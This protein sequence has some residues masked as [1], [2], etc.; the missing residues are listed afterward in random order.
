MILGLPKGLGLPYPPPKIRVLEAQNFNFRGLEVRLCTQLQSH[1]HR[2]TKDPEILI[3]LMPQL[4][5]T[6][7]HLF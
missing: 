7:I 1:I 3:T 4:Q 6:I 5:A 2:L